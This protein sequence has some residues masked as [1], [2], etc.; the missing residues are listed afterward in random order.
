MKKILIEID[1]AWC[2][3]CYTIRCPDSMVEQPATDTGF[4]RPP[5]PAFIVQK[6]GGFESV[7]YALWCHGLT[8]DEYRFQ[9]TQQTNWRHTG[10]IERTYGIAHDAIRHHPNAILDINMTDWLPGAVRLMYMST[11]S[12]TS[13]VI[14][15]NDDGRTEILMFASTLQDCYSWLEYR[16]RLGHDI[17]IWHDG[18]FVEQLATD[19]DWIPAILKW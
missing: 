9:V 4:R 3:T 14:L 17:S 6:I 5:L 7:P 10:L 8:P 2:H 19:N 13:W 12:L 18:A 11:E 1:M 15:G 16:D